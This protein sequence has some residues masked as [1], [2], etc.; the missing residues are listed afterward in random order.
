MAAIA[1]A[2]HVAQQ[3]LNTARAE[4][5]KETELAKTHVEAESSNLAAQIMRVILRAGSA[6]NRPAVGGTR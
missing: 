1:E 6:G 3:R 4:M 2:R 5:K